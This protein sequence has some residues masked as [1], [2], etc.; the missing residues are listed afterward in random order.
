M[1]FALSKEQNRGLDSPVKI[2]PRESM[3]MQVANRPLRSLSQ[4]DT[5]LRRGVALHLWRCSELPAWSAMSVCAA[6]SWR[7]CWFELRVPQQ[8]HIRSV[9]QP[10]V[11]LLESS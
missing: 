1:E 2:R 3:P 6:A 11:V 9:A 4:T 5:R 10:Q 8:K 7:T